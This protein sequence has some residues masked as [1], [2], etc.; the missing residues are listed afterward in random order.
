MPDNVKSLLLRDF[1]D[2]KRAFELLS[3][4]LLK[5]LVRH[6]PYDSNASE[7]LTESPFE[8]P[9]AGQSTCRS[10]TWIVPPYTMIV[11]RLCRTAAIAQPGIFL[12]HPGI[13]I[14]PS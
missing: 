3:Y 2:G 12:S 10:P 1:T 6:L 11:G 5:K 4:G 14:L 7:M 8:Y 9:I 13:D